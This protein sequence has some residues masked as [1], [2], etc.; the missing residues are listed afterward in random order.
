MTAGP[1]RPPKAAEMCSNFDVLAGELRLC[2]GEEGR[3][4]SSTELRSMKRFDLEKVS[5]AINILKHASQVVHL[6]LHFAFA[7]VGVRLHFAYAAVARVTTRDYYT[8]ACFGGTAQDLCLD[9]TVP[10]ISLH[11]GFM[12][13]PLLNDSYATGHFASWR[14]PRGEQ[15][16]GVEAALSSAKF[17]GGPG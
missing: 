13:F 2:F 4:P 6:D 12:L 16:S 14:R 11:S 17:L 1:H 3:V 9:C 8:L 10:T 5:L 7:A 15:T